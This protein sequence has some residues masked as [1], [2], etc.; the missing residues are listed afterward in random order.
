M[1]RSLIL[2]APFVAPVRDSDILPGVRCCPMFYRVVS[3]KV[4]NNRT[5]PLY[6]HVEAAAVLRNHRPPTKR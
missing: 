4:R 1:G 3:P 5:R 2:V 6:V